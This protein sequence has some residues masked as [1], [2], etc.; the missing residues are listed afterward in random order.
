MIIYKALPW[1]WSEKFNRN[2]CQNDHSQYCSNQCLE[3]GKYVF[4]GEMHCKCFIARYSGM[5]PYLNKMVSKW[6]SS[7]YW[8]EVSRICMLSSG[9]I[10]K[11]PVVSLWRI[12][13]SELGKARVTLRCFSFEI[14]VFL[15]DI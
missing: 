13:R 14:P 15:A 4:L 2:G 6:T 5:T 8:Q 12:P 3:F 9:G 1:H 10:N 11:L 7:Y